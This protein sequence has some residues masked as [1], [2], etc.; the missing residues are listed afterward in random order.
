MK[1]KVYV[2]VFALFL[3][4]APLVGA[5]TSRQLIEN[6]TNFDNKTVTFSGEV[7][8]VMIRGDFAWV[9]VLENGGYAI[10]IWSR[11]D[12]ARKVSIT[13]DYTHVGDTVAVSGTFHTACLEHGGD[14]DIHA[15]NFVVVSAGREI[16]RSPNPIWVSLSAAFAIIAIFLTYF[17]RKIRKEKEKIV[18]WPFQ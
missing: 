2:L 13:G 14:L 6:S 9:N 15:D 5:E 8:G 1:P 12:D 18:P 10:G 7:I 11:A 16:N 4:S 17:I 3:L